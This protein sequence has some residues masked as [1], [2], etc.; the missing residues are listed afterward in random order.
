M[1]NDMY[2]IL[3]SLLYVCDLKKIYS[4]LQSNHDIEGKLSDFEQ[5]SLEFMEVRN[6]TTYLY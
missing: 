3:L 4:C 1:Y 5:I 6:N 2:N